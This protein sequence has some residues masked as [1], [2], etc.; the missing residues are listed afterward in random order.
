MP[1]RETGPKPF[2]ALQSPREVN[3]PEL[4]QELVQFYAANEAVE[5][6]GCEYGSL[7]LYPLR[8]V[9]RVGWADLHLVTNCPE[10]WEHFDAFCIGS[11]CHFEDIVSVVSAPCCPSGS[12]LALGGELDWGAGGTGPFA[13]GWSV[14]LGTSLFEWLAHLEEWS[15]WEYVIGF[16]I[17]TLSLEHKRKLREYY[18]ALNPNIEWPEP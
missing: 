5:F 17:P 7:F 2:F 16:G 6:E 10:G 4:P 18:L 9:K 14:V 15:W 11:G 13:I 3:R 8:R 12:I 1:P